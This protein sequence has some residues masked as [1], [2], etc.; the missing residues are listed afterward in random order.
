MTPPNN[1]LQR[2][3][4]PM[5]SRTIRNNLLATVTADRGDFSPKDCVPLFSNAE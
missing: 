2:T 1:A 3:G 4:A 5:G